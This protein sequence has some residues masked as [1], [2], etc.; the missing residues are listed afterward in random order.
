VARGAAI[1]IAIGTSVA[2]GPG[3]LRG[4]KPPPLASNV[5]L[6]QLSLTSAAVKP[7][8]AHHEAPAPPSDK[9]A[10]A[11]HSS[12]AGQRPPAHEPKPTR[13][14]KRPPPKAHR[15][16][17]AAPTATQP[18]PAPAPPPAP[19]PVSVSAPVASAPPPPAPPPP[20]PERRPAQP[21]RGPAEFGFER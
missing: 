19:V 11:K 5:G 15:I 21:S 12:R 18:A 17:V 3:L 6:R 9:L 7:V 10:A 16:E 14:P 4:P 1:A 8:P 2:L 13:K 20:S